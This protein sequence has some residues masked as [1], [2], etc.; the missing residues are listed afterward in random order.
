MMTGF[1]SIAVLSNDP[2][3]SAE[4]YRNKLEFEI[5]GSEGHSVFVRPMG[6][7]FHL[8]H[9]CGPCDDWGANRPGGR[10]GIW[11]SWGRSL[12]EDIP[13]QAKLSVE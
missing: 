6:S 4:W 3:T 12:S 7:A 8:L 2:R 9:P 10:T 1:G 13:R 5:V 11:L